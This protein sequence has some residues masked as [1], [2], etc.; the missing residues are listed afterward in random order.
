MGRRRVRLPSSCRGDAPP[1][2]GT[3]CSS[4]FFR[5][6]PTARCKY[7][8]SADRSR[9]RTCFRRR[10]R[11]SR[12]SPTPRALS[13]KFRRRRPILSQPCSSSS[14]AESYREPRT[15]R[16]TRRRH[17]SHG[18]RGR[19]G[20]TT[21][22]PRSTRTTRTPTWERRLTRAF[23]LSSA[24]VAWITRRSSDGTRR[25]DRLGQAPMRSGDEGGK[26]D[27]PGPAR[28]H[29]QPRRPSRHEPKAQRLRSVPQR[30]QSLKLSVYSVPSVAPSSFRVLRA[31]RGCQFFPC[32]PCRPWRPFFP[33]VP[34]APWL[35]VLSVCSVPSVAPVLSVCSVRSVAASSFPC[36][37][38]PSVATT[39]FRVFRALR[40]Y[41]VVPCRP[42]LETQ[43]QPEPHNARVHDLRDL[44]E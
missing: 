21:W 42:W 44:V 1:S 7:R 16:T 27:P 33:C 31:I 10:R 5:G 38:V 4:M 36:C 17:A 29:I 37:S 40:G 24:S 34:C 23:T 35:P 3:A 43:A 30:A 14:A 26:S 11:R 20:T 15:T 6:R 13:S 18:R 32:A 25:R 8:P 39:S 12:C 9:A 28:E 19:H 22:E 41:H 2:E